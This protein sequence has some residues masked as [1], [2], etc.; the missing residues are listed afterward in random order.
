MFAENAFNARQA[1][2]LIWFSR[3][4]SRIVLTPEREEGT[5]NNLKASFTLHPHPLS[6]VPKST[7]FSE[8]LCLGKGHLLSQEFLAEDFISQNIVFSRG[9]REEGMG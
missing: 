1:R 3:P 6:P 9:I 8:F 7:T 4:N 5:G 2:H